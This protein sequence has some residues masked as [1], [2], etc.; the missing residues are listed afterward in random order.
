MDFA[1]SSTQQEIRAA[2]GELAQR[3]GWDESERGVV[4]SEVQPGSPAAEARLRSGDL[5]KEVNRQ[6]I[7]NVRDYN[8]L[9]KTPKKGETLLLLV[10]RGQN[11]FYVALKATQD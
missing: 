5:I 11:T 9:V 8:Q 1:Y 7:Q 6:K 4:I 3:F 2:V 10:K